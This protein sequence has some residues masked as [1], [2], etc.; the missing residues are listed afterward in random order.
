MSNYLTHKPGS[1]EEVVAKATQQES[2]YQDKFRWSLYTLVQQEFG[3]SFL[4]I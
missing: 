1:L 4:F 2:G 3:S